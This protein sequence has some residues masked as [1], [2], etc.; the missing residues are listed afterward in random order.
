[1]K[2]EQ[3]EILK[4]SVDVVKVAKYSQEEIKELIVAN[5][6][7]RGHEAGEI[8]FEV[9]TTVEADEWGL[10]PITFHQLHGATVTIVEKENEHE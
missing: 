10:N 3:K 7:K 4:K 9:S 5:L 8:L 1:M 2:I 6:V